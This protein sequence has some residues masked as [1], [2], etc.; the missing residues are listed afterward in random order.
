MSMP[1]SINKLKYAA[2]GLAK[3]HSIVPHHWK[4][5]ASFW[6]IKREGRNDGVPSDLQ[7]QFKAR[8]IR[9][10]VTVLGEEVERCSIMPDVVS[11]QRLP[12]CSVGDNPMNLY[13]TVPKAGHQLT[14]ISPS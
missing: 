10:T 5:A 9:R 4:A 12:D 7:S 14:Y 11:P 3:A 2:K 8:D 1:P 13:S 6:S